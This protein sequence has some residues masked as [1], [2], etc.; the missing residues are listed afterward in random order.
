ME[1]SVRLFCEIE[2][3]ALSERQIVAAATHSL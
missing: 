3:D 1:N 2:C